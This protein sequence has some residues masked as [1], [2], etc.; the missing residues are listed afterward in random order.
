MKLSAQHRA[1]MRSCAF[2]AGFTAW[3]LLLSGTLACNTRTV[4]A[5]EVCSGPDLL[6]APLSGT[7]AELG[8]GTCTYEEEQGGRHHRVVC[9]AQS[10][11]WFVDEAMTC[12]CQQLDFSLMSQTAFFLPDHIAGK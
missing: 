2:M 7:T 6:T 8:N 12:E 3:A 5:D 10:C 11:R 1:P 9:D 4:G